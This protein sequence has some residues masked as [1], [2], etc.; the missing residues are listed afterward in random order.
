M[1][2]RRNTMVVI[3]FLFSRVFS[4]CSSC[5]SWFL[6]SIASNVETQ[7]INHVEREC[8]RIFRFFTTKDTK[9][10]TF[11]RLDAH[12]QLRRQCGVTETGMEM[13]T[14]TPR[15]WSLPSLTVDGNRVRETSYRR[16][17]NRPHSIFEYCDPQQIPFAI[18]SRTERPDWARDL[19]KRLNISHRFAFADFYPSSKL[20][21]FALQQ[22]SNVEF[23]DMFFDD[24]T[25]NITEVA[26][27]GVNS[28][29]VHQG[30][31]NQLFHNALRS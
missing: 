26:A 22:D 29:M 15:I 27:L 28:V 23:A 1:V 12:F 8:K 2:T 25:R 9:I 3:L 14:S 16:Y 19:L 10:T 6:N 13:L 5:T 4:S 11:V 18:A 31:P 21:H 7:R 20:R 17:R 24:E 30:I